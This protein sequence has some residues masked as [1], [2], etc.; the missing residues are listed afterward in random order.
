M[1]KQAQDIQEVN[2][3]ARNRAFAKTVAEESLV[4]IYE[5]TENF[6]PKQKQLLEQHRA[7]CDRARESWN[8][9]Y[10]VNNF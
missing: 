9:A 4:A 3:Q 5:A 8:A 6:T 7:E 1:K 10:S 2:E